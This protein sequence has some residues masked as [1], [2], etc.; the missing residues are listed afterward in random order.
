V[1]AKNSGG[2][3]GQIFHGDQVIGQT[4]T[5]EMPSVFQAD[6]NG[7]IGSGGT[8][9]MMAETCDECERLWEAYGQAIQSQRIIEGHSARETGLEALIR[10]ASNRREAARK[11]VEDHEAMH[12]TATA[13]AS[14]SG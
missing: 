2:E 10:K 3:P 11:A 5:R 8:V 4:G 9:Y 14:A 12:V 7:K 6:F 1:K 13:T